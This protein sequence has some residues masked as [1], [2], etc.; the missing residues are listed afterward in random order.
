[1]KK[2]TQKEKAK[3]YDIIA[4]LL[5]NGGCEILMHSKQRDFDDGSSED[6]HSLHDSDELETLLYI[7]SEPL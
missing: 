3:V 6:F 1:M 5:D 7:T 2:L 4:E